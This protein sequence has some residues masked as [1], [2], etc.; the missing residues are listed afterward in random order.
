M[1]QHYFIGF[2]IPE[3]EAQQLDHVRSTWNLQ[4]THKVIPHS[5]DLHITLLYLGAVE[6][7]TMQ[8]LSER[9]T[10]LQ[11]TCTS[12][13]LTINGIASFGS[14]RNPRV[15]YVSVEEE[16]KLKL[17]QTNVK[18]IAESLNFKVDQKPF[19]PHITLAKKWIGKED[20]NM[21]DK[22]VDQMNFM[23]KQFSIYSIHPQKIPSYHAIKTIELK[24]Q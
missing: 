24:D 17:L 23:I 14:H 1:V 13:D 2:K 20:L 3:K 16:S 22:Q 21:E 19:V 10:D 18:M 9:L 4:A 11:E 8:R 5:S 12:F 7:E 15:V 6:D